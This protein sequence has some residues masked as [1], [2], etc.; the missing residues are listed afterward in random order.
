MSKMRNA[1]KILVPKG[2]ENL[3][4]TGVNLRLLE[5]MLNEVERRM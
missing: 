2:L 3:E 4:S 5:W 1:K